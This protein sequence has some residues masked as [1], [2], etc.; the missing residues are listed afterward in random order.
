[1]NSKHTK[2]VVGLLMVMLGMQPLQG[3]YEFQ[4]IRIALDEVVISDDIDKVDEKGN[5]ALIRAVKE[6]DT[7]TA[8]LLVEK[9][10]DINISNK[11][12]CT[13]LTSAAFNGNIAIVKIL[14]D[15]GVDVNHS[16]RIGMTALMRAAYGGDIEIVKL[17]IENG[18][19]K[20]LRTALRNAQEQNHVSI[21]TFLGNCIDYYDNKTKVDP[22]TP[23]VDLQTIPDYLKLAIVTEFTDEIQNI[24][25]DI[26][27]DQ[28]QNPMSF[29]VKPYLKLAARLGKENSALTLTAV[30]FKNL[31]IAKKV[32]GK[33]RKLNNQIILYRAPMNLKQ[34]IL[35]QNALAKVALQQVLNKN[36]AFTD[37]KFF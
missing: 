26:L 35:V 36:S 27:Q 22:A 32:I 15:N 6:D 17:L 21:I 7:E 8:K 9:G 19:I 16:D 34:A 18:A 5:T 2:I 14:I 20:T 11:L 29:N 28:H 37:V 3:M 4:D 1:M 23:G 33:K 10:A 13:A 24:I 12:R 25:A 31:E 30:T